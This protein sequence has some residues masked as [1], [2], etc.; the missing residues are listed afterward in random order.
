L[1]Y[2]RDC[3][4]K[5]TMNLSRLPAPPPSIAGSSDLE[6]RRRRS[7]D[8]DKVIFRPDGIFCGNFHC[9]IL[10]CVLYRLHNPPVVLFSFFLNSFYFNIKL[11]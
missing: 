5:F 10:R 1:G 6:S 3:Y 8:P 9:S 11:N 4:Q 2:H 7:L